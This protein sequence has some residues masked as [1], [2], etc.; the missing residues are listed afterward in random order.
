MAPKSSANLGSL[1]QG[2]ALAL[3]AL[4]Q[5]R[6]A[7]DAGIRNVAKIGRAAVIEGVHSCSPGQGQ[8]VD[9]LGRAVRPAVATYQIGHQ[10]QD[11]HPAR[12]GQSPVLPQA[13][14]TGG[15][16]DP[17]K[18]TTKISGVIGMDGDSLS[19]QQ[20]LLRRTKTLVHSPIKGTPA[21]AAT[22]R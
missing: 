19:G 22:R 1:F 16:G 17:G 10:R 11:R 13:I 21:A 6:G 9:H 4:A 7:L 5:D 3:E 20:H 14:V 8:L 15:Y 18:G 12:H 2:G